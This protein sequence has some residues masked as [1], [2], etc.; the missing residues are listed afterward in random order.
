[1]NTRRVPSLSASQPETRIITA[2]VSEY[3]ITTDCMRN[4]NSPRLF[5]IAGSAVL[6]IV[7]S[8]V[9]L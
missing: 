7:E 8:S 5:A 6:T 4:G 3:A 1:M 9:C 2:I